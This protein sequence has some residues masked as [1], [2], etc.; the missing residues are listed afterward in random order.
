M[1]P[2]QGNHLEAP[3]SWQPKPTRGELHCLFLNIGIGPFPKTSH[4]L[5]TRRLK[6]SK[7]QSQPEVVADIRLLSSLHGSG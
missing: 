2:V 7:G 6:V 1:G 4:L 5:K 3:E